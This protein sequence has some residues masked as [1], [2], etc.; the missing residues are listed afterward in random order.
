MRS[1]TRHSDPGVASAGLS[2]L[3]LAVSLFLHFSVAGRLLAAGAWLDKTRHAPSGVA[4][5]QVMTVSFV[6][7]PEAP[8]PVPSP[9]QPEAAQNPEPVSK[10]AAVVKVAED[11]IRKV[12]KP[13]QISQPQPQPVPQQQAAGQG[14]A[15]SNGDGQGAVAG[16]ATVRVTYTDIL[17]RHIAT[18]RHY[19]RS[20]RKRREEGTAVVQFALDNNGRLTSLHLMEGSGHRNLDRAAMQTLRNA[21]PFPQPPGGALRFSMPVRFS[22]KD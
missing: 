22:L 6:S 12:E 4:G 18:H 10:P 2:P 17:M 19:P 1:L 20:A 8:R 13:V 11:A 3:G 9:P 7:V 16:K 5:P 21:Q 14:G 15:A